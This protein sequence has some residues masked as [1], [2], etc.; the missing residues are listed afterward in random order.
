MFSRFTLFVVMGL[1]AATAFA[2]PESYT[3]DPRHTFP[4]FEVNHLGFSTQR[5]RFDR[6]RGRIILD[7]QAQH[8]TVEITIDAASI[9]TGLDDLEARL[10][11]ADFLDVE[12]YPTI[13]F[14]STGARFRGET[15][16]E[17]DGELTMRGATR[18]V[19]LRVDNFRCGNHPVNKKPLC[20]AD[21]FGTL[22]RSAF[23]IKHLVPL[24]GDEVKMLIQIEAYRGT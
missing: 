1:I 13:T 14:K 24:I 4:S 7:R 19:R 6:T 10:R 11:E 15:L 16:V 2:A 21:V 5:G 20:S 22:N 8:V 9:D 18:P 17:L 3:V 23:G 12:K